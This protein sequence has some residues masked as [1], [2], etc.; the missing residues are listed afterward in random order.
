MFFQAQILTLIHIGHALLKLMIILAEKKETS[1]HLEAITWFIVNIT[2]CFAHC[3]LLITLT[4]FKQA[5]VVFYFYITCKEL[6]MRVY[7]ITVY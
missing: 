7:E 3:T 5:G 4:V 6:R 1:V 2:L